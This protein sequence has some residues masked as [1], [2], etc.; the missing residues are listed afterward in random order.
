MAN[1]FFNVKNGIQVGNSITFAGNSDVKSTGNV[2]LSPDNTAIPFRDNGSNPITNALLLASTSVNDFAQVVAHNPNSGTN[3]STDFIA[4]AD[5]GD[6]A[7]GYIDMGIESTGYTNPTFAITKAGD[8]YIFMSAPVVGGTQVGGNLVLATDANNGYG[9]IIFSASG[10]NDTNAVQQ[11]RI[12]NGNGLVVTGNL[13]SS[14]GVFYQGPGAIGLTSDQ[15]YTTTLS[16]TIN[17]S[18]GTIGVVSTA[19]F[20]FSAGTLLCGT[21]QIK[22]TGK[23][24]NSFTGCVRGFNGTTAA[25]HTSGSAIS[26]TVAG[27]T[28]ESAVFSGDADAFVQLALHNNNNGVSAST[29]LI[30]YAAN[31]DNNA[32]WMDMGITSG[33]FSDATYGVT[34]PDDGYIFMSAPTGSTGNGSMFLSTA[35][36]GVQNDIV[37]STNGFSTGTERMRIIGQSR[38]G[39]PAGV[40][41]NIATNSTSTTTGAL[42]VNGGV[43]LIGNLYVGGNVNVVGNISFGGA[44]TSVTTTNITVDAPITFVGNSNPADTYELGIVGQYSRGGTKYTGFVREAATGYYRFFS[45]ATTKP[46]TSVTFNGVHS[47]LVFGSANIANTTVSTSTTTGALTVAGGAGIAGALNVGGVLTINGNV[48]FNGPQVTH[49]DSIIDLHTY[50]NLAAWTSDDGNDLGIRMHYYSGADKIGFMGIENSS[51]TFQ[52]LIDATEVSG[53]VTGTFGNLQAGSALFSNATASSS[54]TTG[55]LI[56]TG[57]AGIGG[58]LYTGGAASHAGN[59][60]IT[61]GG[62]LTTTQT[63]AYLFNENATTVNMA[64]AATTFNVGASGGTWN[65]AGVGKI[66]GNLVAAS[67]T[68]SSSTTTGALV[69]KGGAG[70]NNDVYIGGIIN[71]GG[72]ITTAGLTTSASILPS[73]TATIDIGSSSATFSTIYGKATTAQY[74]DLAENYLADRAYEPGTV[75][76]FSGAAEVTSAAPNTNRVAGVVS[77]NPGYLMNAGLKG[78]FVTPVAFTGRVPCKVMGPIYK[79]DMMVSAGNGM[80]KASANPQIG[81]VIGKALADFS[82]AQGVIEVVVGRY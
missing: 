71:A 72:R 54:S 13:I 50:G 5:V 44:G 30:V 16:G 45:D 26:L 10:F 42:R 20:P 9:D 64:G 62:G 19:S 67:T 3:A 63:T 65:L 60:A 61:S 68:N 8:G 66:N 38:A 21:E 28:N 34:G 11:A 55:A 35:N 73:V 75:L 69:V 51:K 47:G 53:N 58:T 77:T 18:V 14:A 82:G 79:G 80:A 41:I 36:N 33:T 6:N 57:G 76:E 37:F 17:A 23:T 2:Y 59:V 32:G 40:V 48:A 29:D 15:T 74:A 39:A 46:N 1:K 52:F 31:G 25:A 4:Y 27:Y 78:N 12:I 7:S 24:S 56:V 22:F 49:Y 81:T 43:G 70:I